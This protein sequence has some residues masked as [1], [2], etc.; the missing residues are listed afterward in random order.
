DEYGET[1]YEGVLALPAGHLLVAEAGSVK[2]CAYHSFSP[3]VPDRPSGAEDLGIELLSLL[4]T[5][6]RSRLRVNGR[7]SVQLSGGL[8][9]SSITTLTTRMRAA[10][11]AEAPIAFHWCA[12]GPDTDER[13]YALAVA[14]RLGLPL[15]IVFA[16]EH[17][18]DSSR[19]D[20]E[21][22]R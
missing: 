6:V 9:S 21:R 19:P 17:F 11:G 20:P 10:A 22:Q 7:V 13:S 5:S 18:D 8:D 2:T 1:L 16:A 4:Q 3:R 14:E 15:N 12:E